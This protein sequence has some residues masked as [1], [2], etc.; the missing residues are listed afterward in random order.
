MKYDKIIS[1][2]LTIAVAMTL[3]TFAFS[4]DDKNC[5]TPKLQSSL[6]DST[7]ATLFF[8]VKSKKYL[9]FES[10]C[11]IN[12]SNKKLKK[13]NFILLDVRPKAEYQQYRVNNSIN[14]PISNIKSKKYWKN[15]TLV[16][17][18]SGTSIRPL[19]EECG[20]L[21]KKGFK[22]VFVYKNG[23]RSWTK[24]NGK[25]IGRY[26]NKDLNG[27]VAKDLFSE[28]T[29]Y[30]WQLIDATDASSI[31]DLYRVEKYFS[32]IKKYSKN[33]PLILDN[34]KP[35]DV[36]FLFIDNSGDKFNLYESM[37][38]SDLYYLR[39]GVASFAKYVDTQYKMTTKKEF[40]LQKPRS[41]K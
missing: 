1:L 9:L 39:G 27:I 3:S 18:N 19:I 6:K 34:K 29:E 13:N 8:P 22:K 11:S 36:R 12:D 23:L 2:S 37:N 24:H 35:N 40:T 17:I 21:R 31:K 32:N 30:Q 38:L 10:I 20:E 4:D 15:K 16:L 26:S 7:P 33:K 25:L 41:C 14:L 5:F 28:R